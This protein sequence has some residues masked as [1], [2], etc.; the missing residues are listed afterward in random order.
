MLRTCVLSI[1]T[2]RREEHISR[3]L[4]GNL[5]DVAK[6]HSCN[7][8][9]PQKEDTEL[10]FADENSAHSP[11]LKGHSTNHIT[12]TSCTSLPHLPFPFRTW[13][14]SATAGASGAVKDIA[15]W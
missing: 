13:P 7:C 12:T 2:Y 14:L 6:D 3:G 5:R 8:C 9:I 4:A 10:C 1:S 11:H 15:A